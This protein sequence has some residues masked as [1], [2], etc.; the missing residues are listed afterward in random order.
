MRVDVELVL[1]CG[2]RRLVADAAGVA[3]AAVAAE[4]EAHDG[5]VGLAEAHAGRRPVEVVEDEAAAPGSSRRSLRR[6][7]R[8]RG[9]V[10]RT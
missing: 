9:T 4:V 7:P 3:E 6:R 10:R 8:R 5:R 1:R 2:L